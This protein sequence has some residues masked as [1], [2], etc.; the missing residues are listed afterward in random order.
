[1]ILIF[2]SI[3]IFSLQ[4][5]SQYEASCSPNL[6]TQ[7]HQQINSIHNNQQT[8]SSMSTNTQQQQQLQL[9]HHSTVNTG[10]H[11]NQAHLFNLQQ[12]QQQQLQLVQQQHTDMLQMNEYT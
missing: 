12:Q 10:Y 5:Q 6:L 2:Y 11:T 4:T 3:F 7:Q 1:M 9:Q 8:L